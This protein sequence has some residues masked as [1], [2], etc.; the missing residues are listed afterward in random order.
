MINDIY[1]VVQELLNKNG[2]GLL[3]PTRFVSFAKSAQLKV[4]S[5]TIDAYRETRRT[6]GRYDAPDTLSTLEAVLD[7]FADSEVLTRKVGNSIENYHMLPKDYMRW[8]NASVDN[9]EVV[10]LPNR[11]K[12]AINRSYYVTPTE[13]EPVCFIEG[14]RLT[15]YPQT[16]G[17]IV[18]DG[19]K[20]AC[21]EVELQ[22]YRY[23][24]SPN[25]TYSIEGGRPM[26]RPDKPGYQD[27]EVPE[28]L[29]NEL[30]VNIAAMA[31]QH[32]KD[33]ELVKYAMS[34]EQLD[35]NKKRG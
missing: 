19:L 30:V 2:Y 28:S 14:K 27:F 8:E 11:H 32:L 12:A 6:G 10:K 4:L 9:I 31:G 21:D 18:K 25:W 5:D 17:V 29:F 20:H 1:N 35:F 34:A 3:S 13:K 22:Y 24:K 15:V 16:I 7:V 33:E 26:F 23:P